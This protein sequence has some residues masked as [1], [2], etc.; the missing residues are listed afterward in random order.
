MQYKKDDI[1]FCMP[2]NKIPD[3]NQVLNTTKAVL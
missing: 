2:A 3:E 1:F